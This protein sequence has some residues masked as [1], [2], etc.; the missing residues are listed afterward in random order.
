MTEPLLTLPVIGSILAFTLGCAK[1][2]SWLLDRRAYTASQHSCKGLD[3]RCQP[4]R[5]A[6]SSDAEFERQLG[7][8]RGPIANWKSSYSLPDTVI[9]ATLAGLTCLPLARVLGIVGEARAVSRKKK[10]SD[11]SWLQL[12]LP[13][14]CA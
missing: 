11:G 1:L 7:V 12:Q 4:R 13:L 10:P 14:R 3:C 2:V 5:S 6:G 9:C 8:S